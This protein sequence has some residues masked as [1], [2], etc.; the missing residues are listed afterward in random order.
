MKLNALPRVAAALALAN[1]F[2]SAPIARAQETPAPGPIATAVPMVSFADSPGTEGRTWASTEYLLRWFKNSPLVPL[3]TTGS[4]TDFS[5]VRWA[6]PT[7]GCC[8]AARMPITARSPG[9]R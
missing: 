6:N 3:V 7:H 8:S 1:V 4:P 5:P 2:L 9:S